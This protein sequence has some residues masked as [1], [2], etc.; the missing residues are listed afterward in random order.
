MPQTVEHLEIVHLLDISRGLVVL[1]KVDLVEPDWLELVTAE[2]E[3]R[4]AGTS[5]AGAE[6]VPVSALTGQGLDQL[7]SRA[8]R[9]P[10]RHGRPPRPPA[11]RGCRS[12][13]SSRSAAS[14]PW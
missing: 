5:L 6:V 13:A 3:E 14:A 2:V 10:R 1:T 4:L 7:R 9:P 8:R 12:T 11:A